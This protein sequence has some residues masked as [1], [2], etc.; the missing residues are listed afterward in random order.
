MKKI[1]LIITLFVNSIFANA[2]WVE[3]NVPVNKLIAI[4]GCVFL[5]KDSIVAWDMGSSYLSTDGGYNFTLWPENKFGGADFISKVSEN[6]WRVC[7]NGSSEINASNDNGN[8]WSS[9]YITNRNDT[10]FKNSGIR[11]AHFFNEKN[12]FVLGDKVDNCYQVFN[13]SDGGKTWQKLNC[14]SIKIPNYERL[15]FTFFETVY[16]FNGEV[17]F[18][19]ISKY[20]GNKIIRVRNYGLQ[21]DTIEIKEGK[22]VQSMTFEDAYNGIAILTDTGNNVLKY[23]YKT[24]DGGKTWNELTNNSSVTNPYGITSFKNKFNKTFYLILGSDGLK[25][26]TNGGD[27]WIE[28]DKLRH[29]KIYP[30]DENNMISLFNESGNDNNLRVFTGK[31]L[32][33]NQINNNQKLQGLFPNP[34]CNIINID[35]NSVSYSIYNSTGKLVLSNKINNDFE[36][37]IESLKSGIY[38]IEIVTYKGDL[39]LIKFVKE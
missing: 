2:Q 30:L 22:F 8:S 9:I 12:G 17:W 31:I 35:E 15:F 5:T 32:A 14:D 7:R 34:A 18:R 16:N 4:N 33:V 10:L 1:I 19:P 21:V 39:H 20:D 25:Y 11:I 38:F 27:N 13:T 24:N 26:S 23:L 36:V 37:N 3:A 28:I 29:R 6:N